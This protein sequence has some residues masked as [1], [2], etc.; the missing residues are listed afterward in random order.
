MDAS[1]TTHFGNAVS[2]ADNTTIAL[3]ED[4]AA[5]GCVRGYWQVVE[6]TSS[7]GIDF[8]PAKPCVFADQHAS[9]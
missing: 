4:R 5:K 9:P 7:A 3:T 8:D 2:H 1:S 6:F